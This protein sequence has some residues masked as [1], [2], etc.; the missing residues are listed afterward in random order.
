M[1]ESKKL[2]KHTIQCFAC[3]TYHTCVFIKASEGVCE[4][5]HTP[6]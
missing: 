5:N 6:V 4:C 1:N 3:V 2:G